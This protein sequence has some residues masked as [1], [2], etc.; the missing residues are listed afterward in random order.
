MPSVMIAPPRIC[1]QVEPD[2]RDHGQHGVAQHV[3]PQDAVRGE[4]LGACGADEVGARDL[5]DAGAGDAGESGEAEDAEDGGG[6]QIAAGPAVG[7]A[8]DREPAEFDGEEGLR[9]E[10]GDQT[11]HGEHPERGAEQHPV[12]QAVA[13]PSRVHTADE[14]EDELDGEGGESE[15]EG[16]RPAQRELF[17]DVLP[18][19]GLPEVT[20]EQ[21]AHEVQVLDEQGIVQVVVGAFGRDDG[22]GQGF[23]S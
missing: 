17:A 14:P 2:V 10:H 13:P 15:L 18:V 3:P 12:H 16:H 23:L 4:P 6:Q 8:G 19:E 9:E 11:G 1:G 7:G 21:V 22:F 20:L 5:S